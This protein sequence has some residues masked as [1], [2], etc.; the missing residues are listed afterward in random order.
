MKYIWEYSLNELRK[1]KETERQTDYDGIVFVPMKEWEQDNDFRYI[2]LIFTSAN[3]IIGV[4]DAT[5]IIYA[6]LYDI[7]VRCIDILSK[8]NCVRFILDKV[9]E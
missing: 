7:P 2:R 9:I 3:K 8:S 1:L 5:D 4:K 6:E